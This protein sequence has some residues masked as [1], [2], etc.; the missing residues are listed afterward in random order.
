ME[1]SGRSEAIGSWRMVAIRR[2][3]ISRISPWLFF[4]RSSLSSSMLPLTILALGGSRRTIVWHV[5]VLPQPDSP[6]SPKVSPASTEKL[7]PSTALTTR[8]PPNPTQ[9]V[10]R[11][12]TRRSVA[13]SALALPDFPGP[14]ERRVEGVPVAM[15]RLAI[16][17]HLLGDGVHERLEVDGDEIVA[18]DDRALDLLRQT[19]ALG[20]V[21]AGL[22]RRPQR[23][24]LRLADVRGLSRA[25]GVEPDQLLGASRARVDSLD[26]GAIAREALAARAGLRHV[27][28]RVQHLHLGPHPDGAEVGEDALGHVEVRRERNVPVEVEA[29]G[30][31]GL[32]Q[33]L[34]RSGRIVGRHRQLRPRAG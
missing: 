6:T 22:V 4:T 11:S 30:I 27:D 12:L 20:H 23:L 33:E 18:L 26:D 31:A 24:D 19:I 21:D 28:R 7:T 34:L 15:D 32:R 3:R 5:V 14:R 25:H 17:K 1:R 13:T 2:P 29:V 9:C 8:V 16:R 10:R